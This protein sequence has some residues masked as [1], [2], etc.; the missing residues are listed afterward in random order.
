M[1]FSSTYTACVYDVSVGNFDICVADFWYDFCQSVLISLSLRVH[2]W[3]DFCQS[4]LL[5][6][7]LRV[8]FLGA[9]FCTEH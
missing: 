7:S 6:L 4:V 1:Y 5:S 2:F 3:Y 9:R 8:F